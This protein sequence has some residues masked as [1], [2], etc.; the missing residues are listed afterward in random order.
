MKKKIFTLLFRLFCCSCSSTKPRNSSARIPFSA[1][2]TAKSIYTICDC[3]KM[4]GKKFTLF[5]SRVIKSTFTSGVFEQIFYNF[6]INNTIINSQNMGWFWI[7]WWWWWWWS[8]TTSIHYDTQS[9]TAVCWCSKIKQKQK[10][11]ALLM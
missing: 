7:W 1:V 11:K 6:A 10:A 4:G 2:V 5:V 8:N 9:H 3:Q